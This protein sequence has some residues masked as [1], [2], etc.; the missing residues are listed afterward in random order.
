ML[1][2]LRDKLWKQISHLLASPW[3]FCD[4]LSLRQG[5]FLMGLWERLGLPFH[6]QMTMCMQQL[7]EK[8]RK[9][10]NSL[11]LLR[12]GSQVEAWKEVLETDLLLGLVA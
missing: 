6:L 4:I 12:R 11:K 2:T 5:L 10:Q 9:G 3:A 8:N 1:L 7:G